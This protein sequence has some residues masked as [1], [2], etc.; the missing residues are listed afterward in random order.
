MDQTS[1]TPPGPPPATTDRRFETMLARLQGVPGWLSD[2]QAWRLWEAAAGVSRDGQIV[3]IGGYQGR[4]AIVLASAAAEPV[5]VISIDPHAGDDRSPGEWEGSPEDGE[6]DHIAFHAHLR[7]H[8]VE[9]RVRQVRTPSSRAH[10]AVAGDIDLLYVDGSHRYRE[11]RADLRD[12]GSRVRKGGTMMV[13]DSYASVFVTLAT[14]RAIA[15]SGQW[16]YAGRERSLAEYRR[17]RVRG[18]ERVVNVGR[19]LASLPWF[20][21]NLVV[22]ALCAVRLERVAVVLGH[23]RGDEL[24]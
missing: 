2:A 7:S 17:E 23:R 19:Q 12:W 10:P 5:E 16:R 24:Y 22:R 13:H 14:Y 9:K 4:S 11:A 18:A 15:F 3:E 1:T 21:R 8:G 20:V 6:R